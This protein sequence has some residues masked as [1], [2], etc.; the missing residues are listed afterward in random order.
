MIFSKQLTFSDQQ[1]ITGDAASTNILDLG[2]PGTVYGAS[3]AM[4][5]DI[6]P[7]DKIPLL[8]QVTEDFNNLTNLKISIEVDSTTAFSSPK[9]LASQAILLSELKV[10]KQFS[11]D[12]IPNGADER[13]MRIHYDVSGTNPSTGKVTAGITMGVQTNG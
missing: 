1:A 10:G 4:K 2:V 9:Q 5:Q 11:V 13:Y 3:A 7:G 8:V 6:G 12:C